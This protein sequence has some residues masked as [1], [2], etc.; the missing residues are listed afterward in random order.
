MKTHQPTANQ[1]AFTDP[2]PS[3]LA[4]AVPETCDI[5]GQSETFTDTPAP[6][7]HRAPQPSSPRLRP[8]P[9]SPL[10]QPR[11][12]R[13]ESETSADSPN[14]NTPTRLPVS[15]FQPPTSNS[16]L[17]A[18][19]SPPRRT[20][21]NTGQSETFA[22]SPNPNTPTRLPVSDF[23]PP[24]SNSQLLASN[25]PPRRTCDNTGQSETFADEQD[26]NRSKQPPSGVR[27]HLRRLAF[28]STATV[29]VGPIRR[30]ESVII[31]DNRMLYA[32]MVPPLA[33]PSNIRDNRT[34]GSAIPNYVGAGLSV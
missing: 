12:L 21:D 16:Q 22:D 25:S 2:D 13:V 15:D 31:G 24:T 20:C 30:I 4:P 6:N 10:A 23:Q 19:N 9:D 18:S 28:P 1:S 34:T 29:R 17:L 32:Q 27:S 5:P 26:H 14:P 3:S 7:T 8:M 33:S 11:I